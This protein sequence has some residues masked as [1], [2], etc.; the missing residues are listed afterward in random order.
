MLL[1]FCYFQEYLYNF[2]ELYLEIDNDTIENV[3]TSYSF[4]LICNSDKF[5]KS[6]YL[7]N[8]KR[9]EVFKAYISKYSCDKNIVFSKLRNSHFFT[10]FEIT[11]S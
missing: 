5:S 1:G 8:S 6:K 7:M 11:K 2:L 10:L 9:A 3:P 4:N